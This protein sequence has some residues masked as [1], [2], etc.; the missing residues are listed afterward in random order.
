MILAV[1]AAVVFMGD[2]GGLQSCS[3][4]NTDIAQPSLTTNKVKEIAV[5]EIPEGVTPIVVKNKNVK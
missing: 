4:D 1:I 3:N 5:S 2:L